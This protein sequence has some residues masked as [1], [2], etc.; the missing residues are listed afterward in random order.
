MIYSLLAAAEGAA[1]NARDNAIEQMDRIH[2]TV[3]EGMPW[4]GLGLMWLLIILTLAAVL[5]AVWGQRRIAKN[6][7]ELAELLR[8]H[9]DKHEK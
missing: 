3:V 1:D 5:Y 4:G 8:G 2:E 9:L 7:V 6:Q